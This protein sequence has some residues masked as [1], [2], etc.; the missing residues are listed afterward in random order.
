MVHIAWDSLHNR[1]FSPA[2]CDDNLEYFAVFHRIG[3][4]RQT[5]LVL[6]RMDCSRNIVYKEKSLC[7]PDQD[8]A[9]SMNPASTSWQVARRSLSD[10]YPC[11]QQYPEK[12]KHSML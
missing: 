3:T 4:Q 12:E 10:E 8:L 9:M 6:L 1:L 11:Q 7:E 2:C 5:G